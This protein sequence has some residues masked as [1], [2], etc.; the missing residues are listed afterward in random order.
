MTLRTLLSICSPIRH[1]SGNGKMT[2]RPMPSHL[3]FRVMFGAAVFI[4]APLFAPAQSAPSA[5]SETKA[6]ATD[7]PI[8]L[9]IFEVASDQDKGYTA[10]SAL[11]GTRT[12]EKL[13][14]LPNSGERDRV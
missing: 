3:A 2:P 10:S 4:A 8:T 5:K 11:T 9:S 13:E 7:D 1:W 6:A 14:N 12:N